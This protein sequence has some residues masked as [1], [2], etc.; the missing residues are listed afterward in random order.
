M[1]SCRLYELNSHE[2]GNAILRTPRQISFHPEVTYMDPQ[3]QYADSLALS[4]D[5]SKTASFMLGCLYIGD[6]TS[7]KITEA[8][9]GS[10]TQTQL[11]HNLATQF[12]SDGRQLITADHRGHI[13]VIE[14]S[15]G[16]TLVDLP[17][18]DDINADPY[19][20]SAT[21]SFAGD[22]C[23][24]SF[25][26]TSPP[27]YM[28]PPE[29][30]LPFLL[31]LRQVQSGASLHHLYESADDL[32]SS[33]AIFTPDT[34]YVIQ[35]YHKYFIVCD[36][37]Q[38]TL[39]IKVSCGGTSQ[40]NITAFTAV[41]ATTCASMAVNGS[42]ALWD[43]V[44]GICL[45]TL[46]EETNP[47]PRI[48]ALASSSDGSMLGTVSDHTVRLFGM[49]ENCIIA[50]HTFPHR[51]DSYDKHVDIIL[52]KQRSQVYITGIGGSVACWRYRLSI[53][54]EP[55]L[56]P[57]IPSAGSVQC[58]S[59]SADGSLL[60]SVADNGSMAVWNTATGLR[61][62]EYLLGEWVITGAAFSSSTP[63]FIISTR[64]DLGFHPLRVSMFQVKDTVTGEVV[65]SDPHQFLSSI[66]AASLSPDGR[67]LALRLFT[68]ITMSPNSDDPAVQQRGAVFVLDTDTGETLACEREDL[69][70]SGGQRLLYASNGFSLIDCS[71]YFLLIRDAQTL[72]IAYT[73]SNDD[74]DIGFTMVSPCSKY[75][76]CVHPHPDRSRGIFFRSWNIDSGIMATSARLQEVY[77]GEVWEWMDLLLLAP[78]WTPSSVVYGTDDAIFTWNLDEQ[79]SA[80]AHTWPKD[81]KPVSLCASDD[82]LWLYAWCEDDHIRAWAT[83][84]FDMDSPVW[85]I[86]TSGWTE[87]ARQVLHSRKLII[88]SHTIVHLRALVQ[89]DTQYFHTT[90]NLSD[91]MCARTLG[92]GRGNDTIPI[93]AA[94]D[95]L[96]MFCAAGDGSQLLSR[97][98]QIPM[99]EADDIT[100]WPQVAAD[101]FS[102]LQRAVVE[103]WNLQ[104]G[105]IEAIT[106]R[107][108]DAL[109]LE[110]IP[111]SFALRKSHASAAINRGL[112]TQYEN[113]WLH[114]FMPPSRST[115]VTSL[116]LPAER[117][118]KK[119]L[120][121]EIG[122][123]NIAA[124][125]SLVAVGSY[126]G[127]VS[128][129]DF[130]EAVEAAEHRVRQ[131][132]DGT[133]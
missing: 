5:G 104:M 85:S 116:A 59:F 2:R 47:P 20:S 62:A 31:L 10:E 118:P 117:R 83:S 97:L 130:E 36:V 16:D 74:M 13:H 128:I 99:R 126:H 115:H 124:H 121:T 30:R 29:S 122:F 107:N 106:T 98:A 75:V 101:C 96:Y 32:P 27:S 94:N 80:A 111:T 119:V 58:V 63:R 1:P 114:L 64:R 15:G 84:G 9:L 125:G 69:G 46:W 105:E 120:I 127:V 61:C 76:G 43:I 82:G 45:R 18:A 41:S 49:A 123:P 70:L 4:S 11:Y 90:I 56:R 102:T 6:T 7:G 129:F 60:V 22:H 108:G 87:G 38:R 42:V 79:R 14:L 57:H 26:A 72:E 24:F 89:V 50:Q 132:D 37:K 66:Y 78:V 17:P 40:E 73:L 25:G 44:Q 92:L 51:Q 110:I 100:R 53:P 91:R 33:K 55:S 23:V 21:F 113:V 93:M 109:H 19:T 77:T 35:A 71:R 112:V 88:A 52:D 81:R 34:Q 39:H 28:S 8:K 86:A 3:L 12:S 54:C 65:E 103:K 131:K 133:Q 68:N 95:R 48:L 67:Q